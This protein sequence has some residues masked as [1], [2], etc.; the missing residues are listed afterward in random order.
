MNDDNKAIVPVQQGVVVAISRQLAITD[1][2]LAQISAVLVPQTGHAFG[3][4]GVVRS[5]TFSPDGLFALSGGGWTLLLWDVESGA[6]L[7]VF[8]GHAGAVN[9]VALS[10]DGRQALSGSAD[11]TIRL[12]DVASGACLQV[13]ERHF[14]AIISVAFSPDDHL[15]LSGGWDK[16]IRLWD[17]GTGEELARCYA[18]YD[19]S[20]A[21]VAPDG[22]YDSS[23][24]GQC[25]HLRW[26]VGLT[27]YPVTQFKYRYYTPGLLAKVRQ[28]SLK[29]SAPRPILSPRN[30]H[31]KL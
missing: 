27:S 21:V 7:R 16:T 3:I 30:L 5:V 6:C 12:W 23:E 22:R 20:W 24:H 13:F 9:S 1:K 26:T 14:E 4:L 17:I 28:H 2:L 29:P 18:F 19:G 25:P 11:G 15:A 8:E 31:A 10:S